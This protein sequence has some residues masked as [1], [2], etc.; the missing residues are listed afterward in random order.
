MLPFPEKSAD[1]KFGL[2][3]ETKEKKDQSLRTI[4]EMKIH[5][6]F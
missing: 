4:D 3:V 1:E 2:W 6:G 5:W